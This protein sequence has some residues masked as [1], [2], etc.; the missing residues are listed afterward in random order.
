MSNTVRS[1]WDDHYLATVF[2]II[3]IFR[4]TKEQ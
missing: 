2:G 4:R 3:L 1:G